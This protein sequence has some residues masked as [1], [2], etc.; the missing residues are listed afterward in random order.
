[1]AAVRLGASAVPASCA[2]GSPS[3]FG[4]CLRICTVGI[5]TRSLRPAAPTAAL[6]PWTGQGC[7]QHHDPG[8]HSPASGTALTRVGV[9]HGFRGF[10]KNPVHTFTSQSRAG[11]RPPLQS[12]QA[13]LLLP[14]SQGHAVSTS[15]RRLADG[16]RVN[17]HRRGRLG[18]LFSPRLEPGVDGGAPSESSRGGSFLPLQP[19]GCQVLLA[20][21]PIIQALPP[22]ACIPPS[23]VSPLLSLV[24]ARPQT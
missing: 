18:N 5:A 22:S 15:G 8:E 6:S 14:R 23:P 17:S 2:A 16:C 20:C 21:G 11:G 9:G 7:W 3:L 12:H 10:L 13:A 4:A 24:R 1:M 19:W